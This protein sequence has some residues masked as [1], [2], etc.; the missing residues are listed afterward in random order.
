MK[1]QRR[2]LISAWGNALGLIRSK[3]SAVEVGLT[4]T[5][6]IESRFQRFA[7]NQSL[8]ETMQ[9]P[10]LPSHLWRY[11]RKRVVWVTEPVT[12]T[13]RTRR[14][15]LCSGDGKQ[16]AT[17]RRFRTQV[18]AKDGLLPCWWKSRN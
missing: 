14:R 2:S 10:K 15:I 1:R 11:D 9:Q 12:G 6:M 3:T 8:P 13:S 18:P 7:A 4:H 5:A 16:G 17:S